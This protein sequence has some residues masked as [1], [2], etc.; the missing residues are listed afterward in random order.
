MYMYTCFYLC[1][2]KFVWVIEIDCAAM[3]C[4]THTHTRNL[5]TY[6]TCAKIYF[7]T[8]TRS[9]PTHKSNQCKYLLRL[10]AFNWHPIYEGAKWV[11]NFACSRF[12]GFNCVV[13]FKSSPK[14]ATRSVFGQLLTC[15]YSRMVRR[16]WNGHEKPVRF[17]WAVCGMACAM[18]FGLIKTIFSFQI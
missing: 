2:I 1:R 18:E 10:V 14:L 13:H 6:K 3:V 12:T 11:F 7:W 9:K 15:L 5:N 17:N 8:Y 16:R 4:Y